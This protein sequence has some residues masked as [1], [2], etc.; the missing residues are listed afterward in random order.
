MEQHCRANFS[1]A[2]SERL[3]QDTPPCAWHTEFLSMLPKITE[4][5]SFSFR[6]LKEDNRDEMVQEVIANACAAYARLVE[7][8]RTEAA[9]WS[10]LA[11]Y[12]VRQAR[13]G[14]QIGTSLNVGDVCSRHCQ[15]RKGVRVQGLVRWDDQGQEW[16]EQVVEDRNFT[17]ADVAAFRID[18]REFL[19]SLSRRNRKMALQLAKGHA[20]S[21]IAQR[22]QMSAGRVSQIRRELCEA[23]H[24]FHGEPIPA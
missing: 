12:A 14:R 17:P 24:Q 5:A 3:E 10:T 7:Q 2:A 16:R 1:S 23:W 22:F 15:L 8:G 9:T 13:V 11:R 20:T 18:L 4:Y 21:W 6:H 19:R